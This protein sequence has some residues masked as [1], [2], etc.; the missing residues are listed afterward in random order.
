MVAHFGH[1]C[2]FAF[3]QNKLL[4]RCEL[5]SLL[6]QSRSNQV[7]E[8]SEKGRFYL[9]CENEQMQMLYVLCCLERALQKHFKKISY[10]AYD[11]K[12]SRGTGGQSLQTWALAPPLGPQ[13]HPGPRVSSPV[14]ITE[15]QLEAT[16]TKPALLLQ[17]MLVELMI[18]QMSNW[19]EKYVPCISLLQRACLYRL[20]IK[21]SLFFFLCELSQT[22]PNVKPIYS[23]PSTF[24]F[25]NY[26]AGCLIGIGPFFLH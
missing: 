17:L 16:K 9:F 19:L 15:I 6:I 12:F 10:T 26:P 4:F 1:P 25:A 21:S 5:F 22:Y 8:C 18:K 20:F 23:N 24:V 2:F 13:K 14:L 7:L 3:V 11:Y